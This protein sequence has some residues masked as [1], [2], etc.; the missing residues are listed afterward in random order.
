M[1]LNIGT[2][3]LDVCT[4][5]DATVDLTMLS[6]R[7]LSNLKRQYT[8]GYVQGVGVPAQLAIK[9]LRAERMPYVHRRRHSCLSWSRIPVSENHPARAALIACMVASELC[10]DA[11]SYYVRGIQYT[12]RDIMSAENIGWCHNVVDAPLTGLDLNN[13]LPAGFETCV[14]K[15]DLLD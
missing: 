9:L 13:P 7:Q 5:I 4:S 6:T 14:V 11:E 15:I 10:S 8:T 3:I 2:K 1:S 12:R